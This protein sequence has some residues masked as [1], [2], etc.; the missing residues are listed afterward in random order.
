M[1]TRKDFIKLATGGLAAAASSPLAVL[2]EGCA[3]SARVVHAR[4]TGSKAIIP[5]A[6]L[7]DL[8]QPHEYA[9]VFIGGLSNPVLLFRQHHGELWALGSTCSHRGCEVN[10]LRTTFV[11]PCHGSEYDL[12]GKVIQGPAPEPLNR[13]RVDRLADRIEVYLE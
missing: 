12:E 9:R 13:Y 4:T 5:L 10:K 2:A 8:D 11:C 7:P 3:P 1:M 6:S